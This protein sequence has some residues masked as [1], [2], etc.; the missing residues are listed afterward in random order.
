MKFV[1]SLAGG[2]GCIACGIEARSGSLTSSAPPPL[3]RGSCGCGGG[4]GGSC[5]GSSA[6]WPLVVVA[7]CSCI[8]MCA[9]AWL[10]PTKSGCEVLR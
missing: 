10:P 5:R 9:M 6:T 3:R 8:E 7:F 1:L 2:G 4:G